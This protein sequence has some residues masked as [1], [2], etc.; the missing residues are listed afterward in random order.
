MPGIPS[1][2]AGGVV[3]RRSEPADAAAQP[4]A[5]PSLSLPAPG[6]FPSLPSPWDDPDFYRL[7]LHTAPPPP[8]PQLV[9]GMASAAAA[10]GPP[11]DGDGIGILW[12]RQELGATPATGPAAGGSAAA[13]NGSY[14]GILW[15]RAADSEPAAATAPDAS[16]ASPAETA[17]A[18]SSTQGG[19]RASGG[20]ALPGRPVRLP[21]IPSRRGRGGRNGSRGASEL[22]DDPAVLDNLDDDRPVAVAGGRSVVRR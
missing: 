15:Q 19:D 7:G 22:Q 20:G 1:A 5:F 16:S 21:I 17:A 4:E 8:P 2:E 13:A 12:Q 3:W 18:D 11:D 10:G 6:M 9:A 14:P